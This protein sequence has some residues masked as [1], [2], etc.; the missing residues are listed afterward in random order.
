MT[1]IR[2]RRLYATFVL[3]F[4]SLCCTYLLLSQDLDLSES[5][6]RSN[7]LES[8]SVSEKAD[9][10]NGRV[11]VITGYSEDISPTISKEKCPETRPPPPEDISWDAQLWQEVRD[12]NVFLLNAYY[13]DRYEFKGRD[14]HFVRIIATVRDSLENPLHCYLWPEEEKGEQEES[15][16]E[17]AEKEEEAPLHSTESRVT[18]LKSKLAGQLAGQFSPAKDDT[19]KREKKKKKRTLFPT[20]S[21][22]TSDLKEEATNYNL[23]NDSEGV[24]QEA[25]QA[26]EAGGLSKKQQLSEATGEG[27]QRGRKGGDGQ[28]ASVVKAQ[29]TELWVNFWPKGSS[30]TLYKAFLFSC[31]I[32]GELAYKVKAVSLSPKKCDTRLRTFLNVTRGFSS[33]PP[34]QKA[35]SAKQSNQSGK[36]SLSGFLSASQSALS[37]ASP[38]S[39]SSSSHNFVVCVKALDFL[40]DIS[41]RLVEWLELQKV[42]GASK[43]VF[44]MFEAHEKTRKVL[45][46]YVKEGLVDLRPF[47]LPGQLPNEPEERRQFLQD[48]L[49]QK[50]RL[51]L[52]PYN[53]CLYSSLYGFDYAVLLDI[54]EALIPVQHENW[55]QLLEAIFKADPKAAENYA[56]FS[57]Q[58]AYFFDRFPSRTAVQ[59]PAD[60]L[61]LR[62]TSRFHML[63]HLT[64]AANFSRPGHAVKSFVSIRRSLAVFNHY[65]L[66]PLKVSLRRNALISRSLAQLNHYRKSC[67]RSLRQ[68]CQRSFLTETV[69]DDVI[70]KFKGQ[71]VSRVRQAWQQLEAADYATTN[72]SLSS[73]S[74]S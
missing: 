69:T 58:N 30:V 35:I 70:S 1:R 31:P 64:R 71:L 51:E 67:P 59:R 8:E 63:G 57:A 17:E 42:L 46:Y 39:S 27:H 55:S 26:E 48:N 21:R 54:D 9:L 53:D 12:E 20:S 2:R 23:L 74:Y 15:E 10:E 38:P 36:S 65:A 68:E 73:L 25:P 56:S 6:A 11:Q 40:S 4:L 44:Y 28:I 66:F 52:I 61:D 18:Q 3:L 50:R 41:E 32:P 22:E 24:A 13:D 5:F 16:T 34:F 49:W 19:K 43:V 29:T 72:S 47:S 33:P 37:S 14:I 62:P 45:D 7:S 60:D